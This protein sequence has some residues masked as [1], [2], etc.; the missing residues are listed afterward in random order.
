MKNS[1]SKNKPQCIKP[2]RMLL[3]DFNRKPL[4]GIDIQNPGESSKDLRI[5]WPTESGFI[6][7]RGLSLPIVGL[8]KKEASW[9]LRRMNSRL[10]PLFIH[11]NSHLVPLFS[12]WHQDK[13]TLVLLFFKDHDDNWLGYRM[14]AIDWNNPSGELCVDLTE[15]YEEPAA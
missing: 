2:A 7:M 9:L 11:I 12:E 5:V 15:P 10:V 14:Y 1:V 6:E 13:V 8:D 3:F 4:I